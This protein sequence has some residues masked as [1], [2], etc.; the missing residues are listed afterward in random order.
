[1]Q[2]WEYRLCY[3]IDFYNNNKPCF[4]GPVI[5]D[6][7]IDHL[8]YLKYIVGDITKLVNDHVFYINLL[9]TEL[10]LSY[11]SQLD[12]PENVYQFFSSDLGIKLEQVD[13]VEMDEG[14]PYHG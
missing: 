9:P 8:F 14:S 6:C 11:Y 2:S 13:D 5:E 10:G 12:K 1:M 7:E 3:I 4:V